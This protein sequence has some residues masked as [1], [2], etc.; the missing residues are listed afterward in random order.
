MEMFLQ[1]VLPFTERMR[2]LGEA[3][4]RRRENLRAAC[5]LLGAL[6]ASVFPLGYKTGLGPQFGQFTVVVS[7]CLGDQ[8]A[9]RKRRALV[10]QP[11]GPF[12]K[13][14]APT[15]QRGVMRMPRSQPR[16]GPAQRD[17]GK[18]S[19]AISR[20]GSLY[21]F[22]RVV[23]ERRD[24]CRQYSPAS[25]ANLAATQ[26]HRRR[27]MFHALVHRPAGAAIHPTGGVNQS[28]DDFAGRAENLL[29]NVFAFDGHVAKGI[30]GNGNGDGDNTFRLSRRCGCYTTRTSL[31]TTHPKPYD[32]PPINANTL[33][34]DGEL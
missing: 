6:L 5:Q 22:A 29:A 17:A 13:P 23:L 28:T 15:V 8:C 2:G 30:I 27:T 24:L 9:D 20:T 33:P 7:G 3:M 18:L 1:P 19:V 26:R 16:H 11:Q 25:P 10:Q 14:S 21:D 12:T 34:T 31:S 4:S 32:L